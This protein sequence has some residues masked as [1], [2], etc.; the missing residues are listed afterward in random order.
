MGIDLL[1]N[2]DVDDLDCAIA[3]YTMALPLRVGRR[4]GAG[5]VELLGAGSPIYLL[6]KPA[7]SEGAPGARR[8]YGRHWTPVHLDFIVPDLDTA[9]KRAVAV[10]GGRGEARHRRTNQITTNVAGVRDYVHGDSLNRI[11]WATTARTRRLMAK[12]FEL[13]PTADVW[14]YLDLHRDAETGLPWTPTAPEPALFSAGTGRRK[15]GHFEL[16]PITTLDRAAGWPGKCSATRLTMAWQA[17]A[18]RGVFSEGFQTT[19]S[20]HTQASAAFHAQTA[21][22]KLNALITPMAPSGCHCSISRCCG[23]SL[24]MVRPSSWRLTPTAKSQ[25]STIRRSTQRISL[26]LSPTQSYL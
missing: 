2:I 23:R 25:M 6:A 8:G 9:V 18:Q 26:T 16:P 4:L 5:A 3:F 13:D 24:G 10:G 22:G 19:V 21:T 7:G 11:H 12:E 14:L 20:P 17:S 1:V 15:A